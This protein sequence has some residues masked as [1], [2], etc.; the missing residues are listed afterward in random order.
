[1]ALTK[2][3]AAGTLS[4]VTGTFE[5]TEP[6][7][8]QQLTD[9]GL[10]AYRELC[11]SEG[12]DPDADLIEGRVTAGMG[13]V[14]WAATR[15]VHAASR[16]DRPVAGESV[17]QRSLLAFVEFEAAVVPD[18][19]WAL[20]AAYGTRGDVETAAMTVQDAGLLDILAGHQHPFVRGTVATR[21]ATTDT[22]LRLLA[23]DDDTKVR[24]T[25]QRSLRRRQL[26]PYRRAA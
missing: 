6:G 23:A 24:E 18:G 19:T 7:L 14:A 15:L 2:H 5:P 8:R 16:W 3:R 13:A 22:T 12:L 17:L 26:L 21:T 9:Y 1:M 20:S 25:A 10:H 11:T 4:G